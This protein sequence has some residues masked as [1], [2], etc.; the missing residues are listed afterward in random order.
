MSP[1]PNTSTS[2]GPRTSGA[3]APNSFGDSAKLAQNGYAKAWTVPSKILAAHIATGSQLLAFA[4]KRMQAQ[5]ELLGLLGH[6]GNFDEAAST[7]KSFFEKASSHYSE[8]MS[9]LMELAS[10]NMS[11]MTDAI[12]EPPPGA[13]KH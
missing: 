3:E 4:S 8:E 2:N 12:V 11:L 1:I 10:R 5:A 7:Q 6:C 13:Q 9:Q